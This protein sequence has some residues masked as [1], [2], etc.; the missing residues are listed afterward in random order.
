MSK[1]FLSVLLTILFFNHL[2]AQPLALGQ[3]R[4]ELVYRNAYGVTASANKVYCATDLSMYSVD[5]ADL[6]LQKLTTVNGLSDVQTRLVAYSQEHDLLVICYSNSNIDIMKN[7]E[8]INISDIQRKSIVGDKA[9]YNIYLRG[10]YA[11]LA[12]GFGIVV[13]DVT[14]NEIKDTYYIGPNGTQIQVNDLNSDG[15]YLYAATGTGVYRADINDPF[16]ADFNRWH[17]ISPEEG[18]FGGNY[19]DVEFFNNGMLASKEDS[20][21]QFNG[22]TW[23]LYFFRSGLDVRKMEVSSGEL[24]MCHIGSAGT[25]ITTINASGSIDSVITSQPYQAVKVND[26]LWIA[27]L[28][29]GLE[30]YSNG[31]FEFIYPNGPWTSRV[32]DMA[33][34]SNNHNVYV[35]PGGWNSSYA[36][37]FNQDGF[38]TRIDGWWN[39]YNYVNTPI[40]TDSF[41]IVCVTVNPA[42]NHVF[43]GS[44][45]NGIIEWDD[46][47]GIVNQFDETNSSLSGTNGDIL[48]VKAADIAFDTRGNMWVSNLGAL[49]PVVARKA[50]GTW[51]D[52]QPP[53][54][55]D[56][57]WITGIA[58]DDY[59]Q[60]WFVLP[61]Q[62]VMVFNY[63]SSIEDKSDDQYKKL[64]NVPGSG[65]LPTLQVNC[66]AKDLDG[67]IWVGTESGV[68]VFYCPGDIFT[69]FGC[70]AQQIIVNSEGYNGYLLATENVKRIVVDGANRK[71]IAT[72]NGVWLFSDDGTELILQFNTDNSPLFS[73]FIN[74]LDVDQVTGEVWI[75]TESGI[76][77]YRGDATNGSS[78]TCAPLVFPN[79]VRETYDGPI[80]ISGVVANADVKIT[81]T[82]GTLIYRTQALGGQVIWDGKGYDGE[83]ART[84][85]YLVWASNNDGSLT[86][87]TKL[88]IIN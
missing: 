28:Y 4:D 50:D 46:D 75:G 88:L 68:A 8:I 3:W 11:Y 24:I 49:V 74:A 22:S 14:R 82:Q 52:F 16:L 15:V 60:V 67:T 70:E 1:I 33:V 18:L 71:W 9:I 87:I 12:C 51:Y 59:G 10:N 84:G 80:A 41:D 5:I 6:S 2:V 29:N 13:L 36:F 63:G 25:R 21:F 62:G 17:L 35:A 64:I 86:C 48:R 7:G 38:F 85:V 30:K 81:D 31:A 40:L 54:S 47:L 56:Q 45:W 27:D 20:V 72:D 42:D 69:E 79:P 23:N 43:F 65:N 61:R 37:T 26:V 44:Y 78:S 58:P 57:Y 73:N 76:L 77:V 55:I 39:H 83:R 53:F 66:L 32:F 34:N 19:V